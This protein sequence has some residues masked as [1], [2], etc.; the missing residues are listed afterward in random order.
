MKDDF[1]S[2]YCFVNT[3]SGLKDVARVLEKEQTIAVDLEADSMFH[4][5]EKV[6]LIQIAS[7]GVNAV[8]DPLEIGDISCLKP[9]FSNRKIKKI[10][11]GADYDVRSL[12]RDFNITINNLFDTEIAV[13]FLGAKATGLD[14]VLKQNFN[15]TLDK[16]YQKKDWSQRPLPENMV[17]YA[18][19]D[20]IHLIPLVKI[21]EKELREKGR[22]SWVAE[23]NEIMSK[24]RQV[25][26]D[27]QPLF[28]KFKGA[29][30][31]EPKSLAVLETLLLFRQ[32]IAKRKDRPLFK[33]IGSSTL[34]K[35]AQQKPISLHSLKSIKGLSPKTVNLYG[36]D[37][38]KLVN[39]ALETPVNRLPVYPKNRHPPLRPD[40]P[41]RIKA[42]KIW[43][44]K[45]AKELNIDPTLIFNKAML[46]VI[47]ICHPENTKSLD[48]VEGLKR[49]KKREFG[50][51]IVDVLK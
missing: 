28:L 20:A 38:V 35:I 17:K 18:A 41:Q 50:R 24:V 43:R 11:H 16:K 13:K 33:V 46:N 8:I 49:W 6:C 15:I 32:K 26:S 30:R 27:G 12:H 2:S 21:L 5:K 7:K 47:A 22:L 23:E 10:F 45:K 25:P 40:V 31:L 4:F 29:G 19:S 34:L 51:D 14:A 37:F 9:F 39:R 1:E 42:L 44:D 3:A 48:A 36:S